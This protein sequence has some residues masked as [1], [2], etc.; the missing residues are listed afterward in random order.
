MFV[1]SWK[2]NLLSERCFN[3]EGSLRT[4]IIIMRMG[5]LRLRKKIVLCLTVIIRGN[6][7]W[8][9]VFCTSI[10]SSTIAKQVFIIRQ[11]ARE[12]RLCVYARARF[13]KCT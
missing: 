6:Y 4:F 7:M 5:K 12:I 10:I 2:P 8:P 11:F 1:K 13:R 9:T 3:F